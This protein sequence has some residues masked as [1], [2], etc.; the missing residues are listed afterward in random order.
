MRSEGNRLLEAIEELIRISREANIPAEIYHLK[1]AGKANWDKIDAVIAMVEKARAEGLKITADM[2]NYPAGATGLD[3]AM[4]PWVRDGG[5]GEAFKR[6]ED[7]ATR[8]KIAHA[9]THAVERLGE[10][11]PRRGLP[12]PHPARGVQVRGAQ[13]A[14]RQDAGRSRELRGEI[15]ARHDHGPRARRPLA[16]RH[17]LL[18]DVG[19]QHPQADPAAMGVVRIGRG[20]DGAGA[21]VHEVIRA[22]ARLRQL[23]PAARASTCA[24]RRS[25]RSRR[26]CDGCRAFPRPTSRSIDAASSAKACSPMSSSS[27]PR[28]IADR[29]TFEKPH[30]YAVG[31]SHVFVNGVQVLKD[32][33][34]TGAKPGRALSGAGRK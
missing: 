1:A 15:G 28:T 32:G 5:Y 20:V 19:G 27:I 22:P 34:H 4:P 6:L 33:E 18:H 17:G 14:H 16:R 10:P 26:P 24:R 25:S 8:K 31:M 3:A 2:Y 21:A 29:A 9:I 7:P 13:A 23:R 30:Q 11:L 12:G